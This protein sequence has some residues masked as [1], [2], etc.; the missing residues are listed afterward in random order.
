M[1]ILDFLN[2]SDVLS[3]SYTNKE[4]YDVFCKEYVNIRL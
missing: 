1:T 3:I 4:F 2:Y